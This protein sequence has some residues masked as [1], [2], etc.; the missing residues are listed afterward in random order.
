MEW[1][2]LMPAVGGDLIFIHK[3]KNKGFNKLRS[4]KTCAHLLLTRQIAD[5]TIVFKENWLK[6]IWRFCLTYDLK[7]KNKT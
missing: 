4:D 1:Y 2:Q 5:Y 6:S 3:I 7:A